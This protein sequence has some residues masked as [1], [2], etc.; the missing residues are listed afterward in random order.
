MLPIPH[1]NRQARALTSP[2]PPH[3]S[4]KRKRKAA[5]TTKTPRPNKQRNTHHIQHCLRTPH[6][7]PHHTLTN[8]IPS[9]SSPVN[10]DPPTSTYPASNIGRYIIDIDYVNEPVPNVPIQPFTWNT[11]GTKTDLLQGSWRP[12]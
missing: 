1:F 2:T 5:S 9:E 12:P 4:S 8:L 6:I 3:K 10:L 11:K 7:P